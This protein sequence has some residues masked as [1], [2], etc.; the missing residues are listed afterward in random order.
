[1]KNKVVGSTHTDTDGEL[2]KICQSALPRV[3][4]WVCD[5]CLC[6]PFLSPHPHTLVALARRASRRVDEIE[7]QTPSLRLLLLAAWEVRGG[8]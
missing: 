8:G 3:T 4:V 5:F 1:M 7:R 6:A 2:S